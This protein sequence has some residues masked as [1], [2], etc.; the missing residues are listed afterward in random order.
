MLDHIQTTPRGVQSISDDEVRDRTGLGWAEWRIVLAG[1][2]GDGKNLLAA[3]AFLKENY[4]LNQY[5][6]QIIATYY[7]LEQLTTR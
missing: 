1:W 2:D 4:G 6:A 7:L 3:I 5:W